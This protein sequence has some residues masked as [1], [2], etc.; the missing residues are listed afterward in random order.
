MLT[1]IPSGNPI[2]F[3]RTLIEPVDV[4]ISASG[5]ILL[6]NPYSSGTIITGGTGYSVSDI[7]TVVGGTHS[8]AAQIKV[9]AVAMGVITQ[10]S[11]INQGE[12]STV[13]P[14]PITV[15]GGTG[16]GATFALTSVSVT[17]T[18]QPTKLDD[19]NYNSVSLGLWTV[20]TSY[21]VGDV[22]TVR[23][24]RYICL[25]A[26]T[27]SGLFN[28]SFSAGY[29]RLINPNAIMPTPVIG[30]S[31]ITSTVDGGYGA[32]LQVSFTSVDDG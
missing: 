27:A 29:W 32:R 15:T 1:N 31:V 5:T 4:I 10:F 7:L 23:S 25:V 12:Y 14:N 21:A 6:S 20:G 30:T 22:V 3:T 18:Y 26:N 2:T 24:N 9:T 11:I 8:I 19:P 16:T 13:P 28:T 17:G